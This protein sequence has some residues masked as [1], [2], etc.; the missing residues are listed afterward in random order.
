[1]PHIAF[2]ALRLDLRFADLS[3]RVIRLVQ[4]EWFTMSEESASGGRRVEWR[5]HG[6]RDCRGGEGEIRTPEA[7]SGLHDFESCA[8]DHSATSPTFA[9][10]RL[11]SPFAVAISLF[12][13]FMR[14]SVTAGMPTFTS[15]SCSGTFIK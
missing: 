11:L 14:S 2:Q 7:L 15:N 5:S 6:N 9:E 3:L 12:L 13:A 1:M 8:F 10:D 4:K